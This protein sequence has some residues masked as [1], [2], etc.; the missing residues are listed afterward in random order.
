MAVE[1]TLREGRWSLRGLRSFLE[2]WAVRSPIKVLVQS[3]WEANASGA[4]TWLFVEGST[5]GFS[6]RRVRTLVGGGVL[7]LRLG[8][9]AGRSDWQS[10]YDLL[11]ALQRERG[12][13]VLDSEQRVMRPEDL[14]EQAALDAGL[15]HMRQDATELARALQGREGFAALPNPGYSLILTR[16]MLPEESDPTQLAQVLE[17][18]L[19]D[20]AARYQRAERVTLMDLPDA[21]TI[22]V[23]DQDEALVPLAHHIGVRLGDGPEEG[24]VLAGADF[25]AALG[26]RVEVVSE[27]R[28]LFY[29]PALNASDSAD[30]E[31]RDVL[32]AKGT[33][34]ATFLGQYRQS[35]GPLV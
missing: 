35:Q 15:L 16:E 23:W 31:L 2:T 14:S 28:D 9:L 34:L 13:R 3:A 26:E 32:S 7:V 5:R 17:A 29:V 30:L 22:V 18:Q 20:M 4:W 8:Q 11:R 10:A 1:L 6:L 19:S 21:T 33:P 25:I 24:V 12:G 27:T